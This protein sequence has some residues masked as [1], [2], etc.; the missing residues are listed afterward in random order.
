MRR[1]GLRALRWIAK[2]A[3]SRVHEA[4]VE[5]IIVVM[6]FMLAFKKLTNFSLTNWSSTLLAPYGFE[7]PRVEFAVLL[8]AYLCL[9]AACAKALL[10]VLDKMHV[11]PLKVDGA[12]RLAQCCLTVRDEDQKECG[13]LSLV[14]EGA[15]LNVV[16]RLMERRQ[17]VS[18]AHLTHILMQMNAHFVDTIPKC[19]E[20][21]VFISIYICDPAP[22]AKNLPTAL[23]LFAHHPRK[24]GT[25]IASEV[26]TLANRKFDNYECVKAIKAGTKSV[27]LA[28]CKRYHRSNTDR[29]KN[30]EHYV[31]MQLLGS[32]QVIG[33]L[34]VEFSNHLLFATDS[35]LRRYM[36]A[37][38]LGFKY[39]IEH[40][41]MRTDFNGML[42]RLASTR[43]GG[44]R[45]AKA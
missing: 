26:I 37:N 43:N 41:L 39:L 3:Q 8:L 24:D 28:N 21:D 31:G 30:I 1:M 19:E 9:Y 18:S 36:S 38:M 22:N 15:K 2:K 20:N 7:R 10:V 23:K 17:E 35:E 44:K 25:E 14:A 40:H 34:N 29:H 4:A 11:G 42:A 16:Q 5:F 13:V 27:V 32:D 45:N 12:H 33:F 6:G